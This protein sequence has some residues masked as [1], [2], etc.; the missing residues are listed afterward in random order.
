MNLPS[1]QL[2]IA[3]PRQT[4]AAFRLISPVI[5]FAILWQV[6]ISGACAQVAPAHIEAP[7]PNI[8]PIDVTP[9]QLNQDRGM[10]SPYTKFRIFQK[11]PERFWF[12]FTAEASQRLDTNVLFTANK[13]LSDYAFR[14][15]P[16]LNMGYNILPHTSLYCDYFMIKDVFARDYT[17]I[18]FPTTQSLG[19]GVMQDVTLTKKT[20]MQLNV[21]A[22]E[23]WQTSRIRWFDYIPSANFTH[24]FKPNII[25]FANLLLQM[26][27]NEYMVAPNRELDPFY[28]AGIMYQHGL[29]G[30]IL[31]DTYVT[32]YRD[33]PFRNSIPQHG[34]A[35]MIATLEAYHPITMKIPS[36]VAFVRVQPTWNWRSNRVPGISGFDFRLFTG[37]RMTLGKQAYTASIEDLKKEIL[38]APD[39]QQ[40]QPIPLPAPS[41]LPP[42]PLP[43]QSQDTTTPHAKQIASVQEAAPAQERIPVPPSQATDSIDINGM[44][45][46]PGPENVILRDAIK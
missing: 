12:N 27:G 22:R 25:G 8:L 38:K 34:N 14:I 20:T 41:P 35:A 3:S 29:W 42:E 46:A 36:L 1:S 9:I 26:R 21:M 11:L 40:Q 15:Y 2:G 28:T 33:P 44:T 4:A 5:I 30:F 7:T 13:A 18:T 16:E 39:Q 10:L 37:L 23:L 31:S 32:N 6:T 43:P 24:M 19:W 17:D 45:A